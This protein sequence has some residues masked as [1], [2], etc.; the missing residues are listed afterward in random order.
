MD[1]ET[2]ITDRLP[3]YKFRKKEISYDELLK[4]F[5]KAIKSESVFSPLDPDDLADLF[6]HLERIDLRVRSVLMNPLTYSDVRKRGRHILDIEN[7]TS[8]MEKGLMGKIWGADII[9][10]NSIPDRVVIATSEEGCSTC[11]ILKLFQEEAYE[12][13]GINRLLNSIKEHRQAIDASYNTIETMVNEA[14]RNL[15]KDRDAKLNEQA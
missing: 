15:K 8:E 12:L 3:F 14:I 10:T 7:K 2:E 4:T 9:V 13:T 6:A 5:E 1:E 11:A